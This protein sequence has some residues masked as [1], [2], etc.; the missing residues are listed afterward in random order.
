MHEFIDYTFQ[1]KSTTEQVVNDN[2]YKKLGSVV[3]KIDVNNDPQSVE[4]I[5]KKSISPEQ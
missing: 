2:C 4:D 3:I 1:N 5:N